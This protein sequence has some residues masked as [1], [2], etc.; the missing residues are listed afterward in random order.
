MNHDSPPG[1][2]LPEKPPLDGDALARR[3]KDFITK[4]VWLPGE[5]AAVLAVWSLHTYCATAAHT[6]PYILIESPEKRSGKTTLLEVLSLLVRDPWRVTSPTAATLFRKIDRDCPTVLIDEIDGIFSGERARSEATSAI[7]DV[8]NSGNRP[9][10]VVPRCTGK[11]NEVQD[12][13]VF[14]PKVL[15]GLSSNGLADTTRD[16]SIRLPLKRKKAKEATARFALRKAEAEIG[17]FGADAAVWAEQNHEALLAASVEPLD[18]LDDRANDGWEALRAI[19]HRLGGDWP[20]VV[21][22][23]A[24]NLSGRVEQTESLG[25]RLL[26]DIARVFRETNTTRLSSAHLVE[27]LNADEAAPWGGYGKSRTHTGL[28][29]RDLARLLKP[30][31]IAPGTIRL[32]AGDTPK[33]YRTE[34]FTDAWE[35]YLPP[36][37][38]PH[39]PPQPPQRH[40]PHPVGDADTRRF[41]HEDS[42]WRN[43]GAQDPTPNADCG[44]VA[45]AGTPEPREASQDESGPEWNPFAQPREAQPRRIMPEIRFN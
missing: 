27:R 24:L 34:Q 37:L 39:G 2:S 9:D 12:F 16:R 30:F 41:P 7:R 4:Y 45:D 28:T 14:S 40:N 11:D 25:E 44:G 18:G 32:P 38:I 26:R 20:V 15:A 3:A 23:Q 22:R 6:T 19:A 31:E 42:M 21:S 33:G 17:G 35:R 5:A 10:A 13:K 43:E 1:A 29:A 36:A 8:L